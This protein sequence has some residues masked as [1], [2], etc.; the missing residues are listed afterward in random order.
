MSNSEPVRDKQ[1]R[2]NQAPDDEL[3]SES[4]KQIDSTK[5]SSKKV[6]QIDSF[7]GFLRSIYEESRLLTELTETEVNKIENNSGGTCIDPELLTKAK[8]DLTLERTKQLLLLGLPLRKYS[9][10]ILRFVREILRVHPAFA[11]VLD[12]LEE[13]SALDTYANELALGELNRQNFG[14]LKWPAESSPFRK[15][16]SGKCKTNALWCFLLFVWLKGDTTPTVLFRRLSRYIWAP[17]KGKDKHN[18]KDAILILQSKDPAVPILIH[19]WIER[20]SLLDSTSIELRNAKQ[21]AERAETGL[22]EA[23]KQIESLEKEKVDFQNQIESLEKRFSDH[24]A[25]SVDGYESLRGRVLGKLRTELTLLDE[26]L[27]ALKKEPPKVHVMIDHAERAID[28]LK[29][30]ISKLEE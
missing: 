7:E 25:I 26:G 10:Q 1:E 15:S 19:E 9:E 21:R 28:G 5:R 3:R 18:S 16:Q 2:P 24:K 12:Q 6:P 17:Q 11:N 22:A 23:K 4:T 14:L 27:R 8:D 13:E 30:E 29:R 20:D